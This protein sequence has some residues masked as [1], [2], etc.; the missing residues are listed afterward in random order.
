M[1]KKVIIE[2]EKVH[3]VGYRPFLLA[4]ARRLQI[5]N[6]ESDNV[7]ENGK[8][9]VIVSV[10]AGEE[11]QLNEFIEF[12]KSNHPSEAKVSGVREAEPPE[13]VM[14]I[15][16]YQKVLSAEQQNKMVQTG[17]MMVDKQDLMVDKQ[18][19]TIKVLGG[20]ID[21]GF[22]K[23][24]QDF[25]TL[26]EDYGKISKTMEKILEQMTHQQKE[27]TDA[28]NGLSGAILALAKKKA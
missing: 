21:S 19:E 3:Y 24:D 10:G 17:L 18:D 23:T 8:E 4:K 5:P 25:K 11:K 14:P 2:G 15:D 1:N 20:K 13:Y 16:E 28:I 7:K 9:R 22:T 27:F 12:V 6:Y 26:R